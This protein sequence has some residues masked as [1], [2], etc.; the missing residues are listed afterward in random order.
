[1]GCSSS[2]ESFGWSSCAVLFAGKSG[3]GE[4]ESV[5]VCSLLSWV[6]VISRLEVVDISGIGWRGFDALEEHESSS[7]VSEPL[8][9]ACVVSA[10]VF[11]FPIACDVLRCSPAV[12]VGDTSLVLFA[13]L[14]SPALLLRLFCTLR[15]YQLKTKVTYGSSNLGLWIALMA[16]ISLLPG[17]G[18]EA[19]K[20][21]PLQPLLQTEFN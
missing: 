21:T 6:A 19:L 5:S 12:E 16:L 4:S 13:L 11:W 9:A 1:M 3:G 2:A 18:F 10:S 17:N 15:T 8:M 7:S 20:T 14:P